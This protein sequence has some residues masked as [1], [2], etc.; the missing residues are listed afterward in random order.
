M[1]LLFLNHNVAWSGTFFRAFQLASALAGGGYRVT[2]VTTSRTARLAPR[3]RLRDGVELIE[4]P[5]LFWGRARTGWDPWNT[6]WRM[7]GLRAADFDAIHA[8]DSRPAVILPA[9]YLARRGDLPLFLDWADW[10]GRGGAIE[11]RP[12]RVVNRLVGG[13]E[14]WFEEAFRTH[15]LG[16]TVV[17]RALEQRAVGLG[18]DP[19]TMLRFPNGCDREHIHPRER[20]GAR[21]R[22]GLDAGARAIVHVGI[23]Y[24]RD[25]RLLLDAVR[26]VQRRLAGARLVL[27]GNPRAPVARDVLAPDTLITPGF[28]D[29]D[30]LQA[31]L[32]AA[33]CCVI[34]L[35]DTICNRGRWPG[36]VNDYLCAGRPV[37]MPRVGDAAEWI[38]AGRA[39]RTSAP[40]AESLAGALLALLERPDD[41][42]EAGARALSLAETRLAWPAVAGEVDAF[43]RRMVGTMDPSPPMGAWT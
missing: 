26:L 28:V 39:G 7:F 32:G 18:V 21:S 29:F 15:A 31:W 34:P 19:A 42:R 10:W 3:R 16:T 14:T 25:L 40:D 9:L 24:P 6:L 20:A 43:Y 5:D 4:T 36:K 8:F 30:L 11:E 1:K 23:V 13:V 27:L 41:A 35:S 33:D 17:S 12:G 38:E 22:L 37:V 2:V